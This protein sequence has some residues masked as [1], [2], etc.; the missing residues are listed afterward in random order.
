VMAAPII[1]ISSDSSEESVGSH[2]PRVILFGAI[3]A[4]FLVVPTK[5]PIVPADPLVA[6]KVG[7]VPATSP[8]GVLDLVDYSSS[9]FDPS[10]DSLPL[11]S[12]LSLVSPFLCSDDL[13][14]DTES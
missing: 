13:E 4:V 10:K 1:P 6:P 7:A 3:L 2:V 8:T 14:A 11:A 9:D 12:E 5:V